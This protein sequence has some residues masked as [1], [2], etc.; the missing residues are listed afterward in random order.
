MFFKLAYKKEIHVLK[1]EAN[2]TFAELQAFIK[3]VFKNC[4]PKFN[5][6]YKDSDG[7]NISIVN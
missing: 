2:L 7:D 4:P 1:S 3:T 5:L 6:T